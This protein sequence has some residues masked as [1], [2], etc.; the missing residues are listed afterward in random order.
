MY[1]TKLY[2]LFQHIIHPFRRYV[3]E[4]VGFES[5]LDINDIGMDSVID[6][7]GFDFDSIIT[8]NDINLNSRIST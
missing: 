7:T 2:Q 5:L 6:T 3:G 1:N 8:Q 4:G